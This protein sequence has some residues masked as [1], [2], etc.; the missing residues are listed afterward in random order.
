MI[1]N[2]PGDSVSELTC[3]VNKRV[4]A[5]VGHVLSR[6]VRVRTLVHVVSRYTVYT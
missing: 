5:P 6:T 1:C 2:T 4:C 3:D